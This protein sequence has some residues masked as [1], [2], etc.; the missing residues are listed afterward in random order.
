[1]AAAAVAAP[2]TLVAAAPAPHTGVKRT[3]ADWEAALQTAADAVKVA[4]AAAAA[5]ASG[6]VRA[7]AEWEAEAAAASAAVAAAK[8]VKEGARE[9]AIAAIERN[10]IAEGMEVLE[11]SDAAARLADVARDAKAALTLAMG[12]AKAM[13]EAQEKQVRLDLSRLAQRAVGLTREEGRESNSVLVAR[14]GLG[15]NNNDVAGRSAAASGSGACVAAP[16]P[17]GAATAAATTAA[18]AAPMVEVMA[19]LCRDTATY[20]RELAACPPEKRVELEGGSELPTVQGLACRVINTTLGV[21]ARDRRWVS[22]LEL[23]TAMEVPSGMGDTKGSFYTLADG[24]LLLDTDRRAT[25]VTALATMKVTRALWMGALQCA[26]QQAAIRLIHLVNIRRGQRGDE[27]WIPNSACP[28]DHPLAAYA[29]ATDGFSLGVACVEIEAEVGVGPVV[30]Y[31]ISDPLPLW[32]PEFMAAA[33]QWEGSGA[34]MGPMMPPTP[35]AGIVA[36]VKLLTSDRSFLGAAAHVPPA[37]LTFY[38]GD[39]CGGS[40]PYAMPPPADWR[41]LG[42]GGASEAYETRGADGGFLVV[43]MPHAPTAEWQAL[44]D[45]VRW[46]KLLGAACPAIPRL[47]AVSAGAPLSAIVLSP[48]DGVYATLPVRDVLSTCDRTRRAVYALQVVYSAAV[49]LAYGHAAGVAHNDVRGPNLVWVVRADVGLRPDAPADAVMTAVT[50]AGAPLPTI[51]AVEAALNHVPEGAAGGIDVPVEHTRLHAALPVC[52]QLVDWGIAMASTPEAV[53]HDI[54]SLWRLLAA[55]APNDGEETGDEVTPTVLL[56]RLWRSLPPPPPHLLSLLQSLRAATSTRDAI[57]CVLAILAGLLRTVE[58]PGAGVARAMPA[59]AAAEMPAVT[60]AHTIFTTPGEVIP[61][62]QTHG[63]A[64]GAHSDTH[65]AVTGACKMKLAVSAGVAIEPSGAADGGA[66][67][68]PSAAPSVATAAAT[69]RAG[70]PADA[71]VARV[72]LVLG[73]GDVAVVCANDTIARAVAEHGTD[74][75]LASIEAM[76]AKV[77]ILRAAVIAFKAAGAPAVPPP[78]AMA[79]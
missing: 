79:R 47:A 12:G 8:A 11:T 71:A 22:G 72:A 10:A 76:A 59:A 14:L 63:L 2:S 77:Q 70:A 40:S 4:T 45:E 52:A 29:M 68:S 74:A 58:V 49:A 39:S 18:A 36:L 78:A 64:S 73:L 15:G 9:D 17:A 38:H 6:V 57:R 13:Q 21:V 5:A 34:F 69:P 23:G 20:A 66:E 1:M 3:R 44:A 25:M 41:H 48:G 56:Q 16:H 65:A 32:S 55:L 37:S 35:P 33:R 28:T 46:Y 54:Q 19:A 27:W 26:L 31:R 53:T 43:K 67:S 42:S 30:T 75:A 62:A 51:A 60:P 50:A 24:A 61:A 7:P